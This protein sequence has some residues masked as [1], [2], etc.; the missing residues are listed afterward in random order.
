MSDQDGGSNDVYVEVPVK[1]T[2]TRIRAGL[3]VAVV[4]LVMLFS[5]IPASADPLPIPSITI[6]GTS[7]T[8]GNTWE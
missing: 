1:R 4:A 5:A 2:V 3:L 6:P 8:A 7:T